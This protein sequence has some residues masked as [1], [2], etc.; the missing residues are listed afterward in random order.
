[1]ELAQPP[2]AAGLGVVLFLLI[3]RVV[4]PLIKGKNEPTRSTGGN[5]R[6]QEYVN[7]N[8]EQRLDSHARQL[9]EHRATL[10]EIGTK[11][12]VIYEILQRVEKQLNRKG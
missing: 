8:H 10:N 2:L 7:S 4:V 12:T 11:T 5:G 9:N 3:D 6:H 1:M